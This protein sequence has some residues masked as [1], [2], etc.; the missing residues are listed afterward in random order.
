[1]SRL[2]SEQEYRKTKAFKVKRWY[3]GDK[4]PY[5]GRV[6]LRPQKPFE[7]DVNTQKKRIHDE[8]I[9]QRNIYDIEHNRKLMMF[10]KFYKVI[11]VLF[12]FTLIGIL[13]YMVSYLPPVGNAANPDNNEVATKYI[14]DAMKDTGAVNIVTGMILDYR[15]FEDRKST[16][17]NSSHS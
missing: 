8:A 4:D 5:I 15:A 3:R 11:S 16:R 1:M 7:E 14:E 2:L 10:S 9:L 17:L 6:E 12:V 13:L